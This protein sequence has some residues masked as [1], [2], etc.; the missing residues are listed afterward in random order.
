ML[1]T[2]VSSTRTD[3]MG[4][5]IGAGLIVLIGMSI[6]AGRFLYLQVLE[7]ETYATL[8]KVSRVR[9]E[10]LPARRGIIKD[11]NGVALATN[12]DEHILE[13]EPLRMDDPERVLEWVR[14]RLEIPDEVYGKSGRECITIARPRVDAR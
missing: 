13:L 4:S 8:A 7:A 5:A 9:S 12:I 3:Y 2:S 14:D 6:L 1:G 11:R 10:R